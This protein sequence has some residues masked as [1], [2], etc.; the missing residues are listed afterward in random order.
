MQIA[1]FVAVLVFIALDIVSGLVKAFATTGFDSSTMRQ[2]AYHKIGEVLAVCLMA[3]ADFYLPLVGV[4]VGVSFS[5]IGCA[6]FV[7]MEIG[8]VLEN[9]GIINPELV[10]PLSKIFAK[11]KGGE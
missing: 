4:T 9:I 3:A 8:S 10:G 11:L 2:G 7:A 6:Y 1:W 5:A